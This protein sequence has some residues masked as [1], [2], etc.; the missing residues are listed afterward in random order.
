MHCDRITRTL[1]Q[2]I[3]RLYSVEAKAVV[4][5]EEAGCR[6]ASPSTRAPMLTAFFFWKI[7][8]HP[9]WNDLHIHGMYQSRKQPI[10]K[11]KLKR[12][13][14]K[15][16]FCK[17][18]DRRS[19]MKKTYLETLSFYKEKTSMPTFVLFPEENVANLLPYY[20]C[21][22]Q[23]PCSCLTVFTSLYLI[24][25]FGF[26][27]RIKRQKGPLKV[28]LFFHQMWR[29]VLSGPLRWGENIGE[30]SR[31]HAFCCYQL[32]WI[33]FK[34]ESQKYTSCEVQ[35]WT[36]KASKQEAWSLQKRLLGA[37]F[38]WFISEQS[39]S[40]WA[41]IIQWQEATFADSS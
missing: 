40:S 23:H 15:I 29:A 18:L 28:W 25:W 26:N 5:V 6:R 2:C 36:L 13:E 14:K 16:H 33:F 3:M 35:Q 27:S 7:F 10:V 41:W 38:F 24:S 17:W 8:L 37:L 19:T 1:P 11:V 30:A 31:F 9:N 21:K 34:V 20:R 22:V 32:K 4:K 12:R 39:S